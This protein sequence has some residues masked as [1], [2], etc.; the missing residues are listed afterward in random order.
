MNPKDV[1]PPS[2][3]PN[4]A[5]PWGRAIETHVR[6]LE[7]NSLRAE[8]NLKNG[9]RTTA[10]VTADLARQ[11]NDLQDYLDELENLFKA[12]PKTDTY[13]NRTTGFSSSESWVT[14]NSIAVPMPLDSNHV[15]VSAFASGGLEYTSGSL[16]AL[17][18]RITIAGAP[19]PVVPADE[20]YTAG[21]RLAIT[22][23]QHSRSMDRTSGFNVE[24][25]IR[26][27]DAASFPSSPENYA[28]LTVIASTTG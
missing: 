14:I 26:A 2:N 16:S 20:F 23:P 28:S 19:G 22:S 10:A 1:L 12:I 15:E 5:V 11:L 21:G 9:N 8:A 27:A 24:Y 18:G 6:E 4:G 3:L 13:T 25:Q 7:D 17:D